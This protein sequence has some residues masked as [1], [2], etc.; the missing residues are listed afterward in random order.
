M[1][2]PVFIIIHHFFIS[3]DAEWGDLPWMGRQFSGLCLGVCFFN[4]TSC[5]ASVSSITLHF[6]L[7]PP[8]FVLQPALPCTFCWLSSPC[9]MY[10]PCFMRIIQCISLVGSSDDKNRRSRILVIIVSFKCKRHYSLGLSLCLEGS[11]NYRKM[12]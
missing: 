2:V 1:C 9:L 3:R 4:M 5:S 12:D 10:K 11:R 7:Q 6:F 8:S